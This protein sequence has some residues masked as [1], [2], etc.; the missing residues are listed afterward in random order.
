MNIYKCLQNF[1]KVTPTNTTTVA[2]TTMSLQERLR[3]KRQALLN[4][5]CK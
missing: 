2:S 3:R 1:Q 4:K 5:Q